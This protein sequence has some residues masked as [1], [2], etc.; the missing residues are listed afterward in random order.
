MR[1]TKILDRRARALLIAPVVGLA[2]TVACSSASSYAATVDGTRIEQS[3]LED[4]LRDVGSNDKYLK[5]VENQI[6]APVRTNGVF[7]ASF[8]STVLSREIIYDLVEKDLAKRKIQIS[9]EDMAAARTVAMD[10]SGG[11]DVFNAFPKDYQ[12]TL[13]RRQAQVTALS[14]ALMGP[15][16]PEEQSRAYYD[17]NPE[18]FSEACVSHILV[19]AQEKAD[20][21]KGRLGGG[22]D[23]AAVARAESQDAQSAAKG[24]E[25]GCD[26]TQE[27][28]FV[29]EFLMAVF[30]QPVGEVGNPVKTQFGFHLIHVIDRQAAPFEQVRDQ[31]LSEVRSRVFTEWLMERLKG[32]EVR[33][34][35]RYGTFD[36][37]TGRVVER[38]ST[39]PLPAPSVQV[40]P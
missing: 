31:L 28:S 38:R 5:L 26:I 18:S 11:E 10:R 14:F 6:Q 34:N 19:P 16:T 37:R 20:E 35:P 36:E 40:F 22:E 13:V 27:T 2:L 8:T 24:G 4:E 21:V 7:D 1:T 29:P 30:S 25:L 32:A 33:V 9:P 23:F 12:D 17:A 39:T 15:G 3:T